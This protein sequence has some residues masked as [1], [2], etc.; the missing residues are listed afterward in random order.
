MKAG[1]IYKQFRTKNGKLATL[2]AIRW[3]D[4]NGLLEFAN[5]L[6]DERE[7]DPDFGIILDK[8][9][10]LETESKWL[11]EKLSSIEN[12][13]QVSVVA[14]I[15]GR[16]VGNSEVVRGNSSDEFHHGK[17]GISILKEYR[18]QG[19]GLEMMKTL[20]EQSRKA[21]LKTIELE[22]FATNPRAIH[23]YESAGFKQVG[24]IPKKIFR[25]GRHT[26]IILMA[27]EL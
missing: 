22:V 17:L 19:I 6:V 14:E 21:G 11:G 9:Q 25:K 4:L 8:K 10:T 12:M 7:I 15:D 3:E 27:I 5:S 26:D 13:T 1:Q 24:R 18:D 20:V 23:V 16:L 2:R